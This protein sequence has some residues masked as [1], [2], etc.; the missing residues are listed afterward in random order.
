VIAVAFGGILGGCGHIH[1]TAGD[2]PAESPAYP[3]TRRGDQADEYHGVRVP[4]PYRWL[5][6]ADSAETRAWIE[7]QNRLAFE[8]L[9]AIPQ[10]AAIRRRLKELLNYERYGVPFKRGGRYFFTRNNGLQ[11]QSVLYTIAALDAEPVVLLDPNE[12]SADG[13]VALSGVAVS[14]DGRL[15]AYGLSAAGSDWQE[16]KVRAVG[17]GRD[18]DD[19]VKWVKFS[20]A[21]WTKDGQGFFYS[22]Y[23]EPEPGAALQAPNHFHKLYHHRLGTP[24]SA[25]RLVYERPDRKEWGFG[26]SVTDD[27]RYLII[28]V[29]QG[30]DTRNRVFYQDLQRPGASVVELLNDFDADYT[31]IDNDGTLFWFFTDL[32]APRGRVIAIDIERPA[33][34]HWREVIPQAAET[35]RGVSLL[36]DQFV[37]TYLKDA[38]SRVRIVGRDGRLIREVALPGIGSASGF[39]GRRDDTETFYAF[40]GF[41]VPGTIY[42]YDLRTGDRSVFREPRVDFDPSDY[43]TTQVFYTSKDGTRVPMFL[44]HRRGLE[45]NGRNPTYL[46]G[47]GG[48][49]TQ[50]A[51]RRRIRRGMAPGRDEAEEAKRFRR[52]HRGGGMA[53]RQPLYLGGNTRHRR[54]QQR[55]PARGRV[56]DATAGPVCGGAAGG[57]C[58]GH[59][60]LSQIHHRLGVDVGLWFSR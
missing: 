24:Q 11:N 5:E 30:T 23:D 59:A 45:R 7:A 47:Y 18:L 26:G 41:T 21:S 20:G 32:N 31:F 53:D 56:P 43:V 6:D 35:L 34:E 55:R 13:T 22:R 51:R 42:H 58:D 52:L 54:R 19:H 60:A 25:D 50:P 44:T 27:G 37:L 10:R 2:R 57:G 29:W 8:H 46:Y 39:G 28:T 36:N 9:G 38:H 17:T 48:F 1:R 33:R 16:W 3:E 49:A 14:D 15:L 4:D 40:T 12:L